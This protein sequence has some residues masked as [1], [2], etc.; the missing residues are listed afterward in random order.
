MFRKI[1]SKRDPNDTLFSALGKEF[2][3]YLNVVK[4]RFQ[5]FLK[6]YP[7]WIFGFMVMSILSSIVYTLTVSKRAKPRSNITVKKVT[8]PAG[9]G[10]SQILSTAD[11]LRESLH[12][13]REISALI[14]K[15]SLTST[16]SL[17]L[18]NA[19]DRFHQL[20]ITTNPDAPN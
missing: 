4:V 7:N 1:H 16:D 20:T 5:A 14:A 18:K 2:A 8:E 3:V 9:Q 15:D 6:A 12:I 19:L 17:L 11:A 13:K 10:F